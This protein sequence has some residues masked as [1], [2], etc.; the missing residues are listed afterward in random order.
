MDRI[1]DAGIGWVEERNFNT[2]NVELI[3]RALNPA[4]QDKMLN[5]A[6]GNR[7]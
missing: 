1:P 3:L 5:P 4:I 6:P 2:G 7:S